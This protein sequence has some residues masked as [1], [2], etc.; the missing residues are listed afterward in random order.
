MAE[1]DQIEFHEQ[2]RSGGGARQPGSPVTRSIPVRIG[3]VAG[4]ALLFVVGAVAAMGA[5][6]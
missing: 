6:P 3:I 1:P 5:S 4:A 2:V